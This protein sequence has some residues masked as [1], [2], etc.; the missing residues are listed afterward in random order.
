[1]Q[2]TCIPRPTL[3]IERDDDLKD[4]EELGTPDLPIPITEGHIE[5]R[6]AK[7]GVGTI[8]YGRPYIAGGVG[9]FYLIFSSFS[10][11]TTT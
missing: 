9:G 8:G 11:Q 5:N 2:S 3:C 1:M 7:Y 6:R 10:S 4:F